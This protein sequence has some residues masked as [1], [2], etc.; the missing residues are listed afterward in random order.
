[1][2]HFYFVQPPPISLGVGNDPLLNHTRILVM[3]RQLSSSTF[4]GYINRYENPLKKSGTITVK[5]AS[6]EFKTFV[7]ATSYTTRFVLLKKMP[8]FFSSFFYCLRCSDVY[9]VCRF[10]HA[11]I[12]SI[13]R[14]D[15]RPCLA[16]L[17][18]F[19]R[20]VLRVVIFF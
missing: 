9:S 17:Y 7:S 4:A 8:V 12:F 6:N 19:A 10:S 5:K 2:R 11:N 20:R 14:I 15:Q 3:G 1:M 13:N 18:N 16:L